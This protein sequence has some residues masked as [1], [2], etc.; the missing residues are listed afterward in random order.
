VIG[1]R[2]ARR[3]DA[4]TQERRGPVHK[5]FFVVAALAAFFA[6]PAQAADLTYTASM[7]GN[8]YPTTTGSAATGTATLLVHPDTQTIDARIAIT[9]I[10]M[11][12]L[13]HHLAHSRMGP[14]HLHRYAADG[15]V[16]LIL[17]FPLGA[18]YAETADGFTVT[19]TGYAYADG[20]AAV[21][22]ALS[23][24]AFLAA[25]AS[26]PIYL[27][28]HTNAFGDGEISGPVRASP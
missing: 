8:Q 23:F 27:N 12:D 17:P 22:S 9:G 3:K 2:A 1:G 28:V 7:A 14:I 11:D 18:T 15:D 21:R 20:A 13:A 26:D 10:R 25:L 16:T 4:A 6:A 5:L 24:E 19:M